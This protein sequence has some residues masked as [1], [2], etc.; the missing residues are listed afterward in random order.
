MCP[1]AGGR[2]SSF[3][4]L[5]APAC[6]QVGWR[7]L[8]S[9]V[10]R[11]GDV[12]LEHSF[13]ILPLRDSQ[14]RNRRRFRAFLPVPLRVLPKR[15][16]VSS[17]RESVLGNICIKVAFRREPDQAVHA[18]V[19]TAQQVFLLD[20]WLGTS[21]PTDERR[22]SGCPSR[23]PG[24]RCPNPAGCP[25]ILLKQGDLGS[26]AGKC[27]IHGEVSSMRRA[28]VLSPNKSLRRFGTREVPAPALLPVSVPSLNSA[29]SLDSNP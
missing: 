11:R 6:R 2:A 24:Q 18:A 10:G 17:R 27:S 12:L 19:D 21:E 14:V 23:K 4:V 25:H 7:S 16:G 29:V 22:T 8:N 20:L 13:R 1:A 15:Y 28:C 26:G 3:P 9:A 5:T